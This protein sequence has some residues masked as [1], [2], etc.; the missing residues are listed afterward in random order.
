MGVIYYYCVR[1]NKLHRF[2]RLIYEDN[3]ENNDLQ[4]I[5]DLLLLQ[6]AEAEVYAYKNISKYQY[7]ELQFILTE[8]RR[9]ISEFLA[10]LCRRLENELPP[11]YSKNDTE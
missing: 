5:F 4:I 3:L 11:N 2:A 6:F 9:I 10:N 8:F 7:E 1:I